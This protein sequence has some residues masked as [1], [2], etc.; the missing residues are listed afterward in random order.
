MSNFATLPPQEFSRRAKQLLD[1][2]LP[3]PKDTSRFNSLMREAAAHHMT[4]VEGLQYV[5]ERREKWSHF[6]FSALLP[7]VLGRLIG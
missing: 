3:D 7:T 2:A 5:I 4:W 6:P 1:R